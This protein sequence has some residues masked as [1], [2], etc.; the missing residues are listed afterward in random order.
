MCRTNYKGMLVSLISSK[1][2]L[3]KLQISLSFS[4]SFLV[5][6]TAKTRRDMIYFLKETTSSFYNS[7]IIDVVNIQQ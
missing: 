2:M 4:L 5:V 1:G 7:L 3:W 6:I